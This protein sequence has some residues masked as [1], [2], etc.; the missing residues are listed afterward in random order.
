[1]E[2]YEQHLISSSSSSSSQR[3]KLQQQQQQVSKQV[4][5][6]AI[7]QIIDKR[8]YCLE[9]NI[10]NIFNSFLKLTLSLLETKG[11]GSCF[12][13][14]DSAETE[15]GLGDCSCSGQIHPHECLYDVDE[16]EFRSNLFHS[17][18]RHAA[19]QV[20]NKC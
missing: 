2:A 5:K 15:K 14:L 20:S 4:S 6:Q 19:L 1:M 17:Y 12:G 16:W 7:N 18:H 13:R 10:L 3:F 9:D 8:E 11:C